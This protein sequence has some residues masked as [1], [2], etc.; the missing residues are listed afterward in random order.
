MI[1]QPQNAHRADEDPPAGGNAQF[2]RLPAIDDDDRP[3]DP[4]C[5]ANRVCIACGRFNEAE[6]PEFCEACG[7]H[8]E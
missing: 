8:F 2:I 6:R 4:A 5:W 7:A 1:E 3:G